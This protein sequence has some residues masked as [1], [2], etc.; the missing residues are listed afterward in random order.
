MM[1]MR[2]GAWLPAPV[3]RGS[4]RPPPR[5]RGVSEFSKRR[6]R[7]WITA[8]CLITPGRP[9]SGCRKRFF[10]DKRLFFMEKMDC[11]GQSALSVLQPYFQIT[12]FPARSFGKQPVCSE[13][14]ARNSLFAFFKINLSI[15]GLYIGLSP[16]IGSS[17]IFSRMYRW[18]I[19]Y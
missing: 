3:G 10:A 18:A 8:F 5:R 7:I 13:N 9:G 4:P 2:P 14:L 12:L 19:V 1:R 11:T 16:Y 15:L 6:V 17:V